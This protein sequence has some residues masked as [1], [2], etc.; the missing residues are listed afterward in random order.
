M[1]NK[2]LRLHLR[3]RGLAVL[4]VLLGA[5]LSACGTNG[6]IEG[7][8]ADSAEQTPVENA[9]LKIQNVVDDKPG[10]S[11]AFEAATKSD[12]TMTVDSD[13]RSAAKLER[14]AR[15]DYDDGVVTASVISTGCT[16]SE[17]FSVQAEAVEGICQV[18]LVR[19]QPDFCRRVP[20]ETTIT[21]E[22][23][24][25]AQCQELPME[26]LNPIIDA[27]NIGRKAKTEK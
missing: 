13:N 14:V 10:N 16:S 2:I 7:Q 1:K 27:Q 23:L 9:D 3:A 12:D 15:I 21:V 6:C 11:G 22:W 19:T 25:D 20:F 4:A 8:C 17:H 18:L 24:P 26:F 5:T